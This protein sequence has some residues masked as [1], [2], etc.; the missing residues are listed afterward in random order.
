MFLLTEYAMWTSSCFIW[1]NRFLDP[2]HYLTVLDAVL[3]IF[4]SRAAKK[5][6]E[7]KGS[8]R[9]VVGLAEFRY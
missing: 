2:Y 5:D 7:S 8:T 3:K 4:F 9:S 1:D 6:Y